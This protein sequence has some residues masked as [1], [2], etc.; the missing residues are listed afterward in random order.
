VAAVQGAIQA[1]ETAA[2][3]ADEHRRHRALLSDALLALLDRGRAID[4]AQA[5]AHQARAAR[6]RHEIDTL[7]DHHDVLLT[8]SAV[9]EA[10]EGLQ[11]TG[12]PIFCRPWSLLGLPCVHL[13]FGT[14]ATGLPV[15]LQLVGRHGEDHRLLAAAQ[16][17]MD[18]L[19]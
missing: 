8:P 15:G 10:P 9:D 4:P 7:F 16:W 13:P 6:W 18:R 12:D 14:G 2:A 17:C 11:F 1:F 5:L 19:S 3:L